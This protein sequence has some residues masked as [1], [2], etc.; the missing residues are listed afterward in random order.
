MGMQ[1][2]RGD[3][4]ANRSSIRRVTRVLRAFAEGSLVAIGFG[5]A[6][7]L[8][9]LPIALSVRATSAAL[10][11]A[12]GAERELSILAEALVYA[13]T[14]VGALALMALIC[15]ALVAFFDWRRT[16]RSRLTRSRKRGEASDSAQVVAEPA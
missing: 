6:V 7:L 13:A 8:L 11:W 9:G 1:Y 10:S 14:V 15:R 12:V 4:S 16:T 2:Q 3:L 5:F